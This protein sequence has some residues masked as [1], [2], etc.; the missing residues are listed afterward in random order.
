MKK[1]SMIVAGGM[2]AMGV[3][4]KVV[5]PKFMTDNMVVQRN[6]VLT[7]PGTA[8]PGATVTVRTD[9]GDGVNVAGKAGKD[10]K[11][12]IEVPTPEAGGP[13]TMI[14]SDGTDGGDVVLSNVLSGEVWLCSGQS[15]MEYPVRGWSEVMNG[16]VVSAESSQ[17]PD[18]RLLEI[19]HNIQYSPQEDAD[20][21]NG[22]WVEASP[23]T[24]EFS[25]VAYLFALE[26]QKEVG[27]PVG[28]IDASW[29]GTPAEAWVAYET[30]EGIDGF[31]GARKALAGSGF[32]GEKIAGSYEEQV[33]DWW[34]DVAAR[35][36][37]F[38]RGEMQA[39]WKKMNL[40]ELWD[41]KLMPGFDGV[42]WYQ[43]ELELPAVAAGKGMKLSVAQVD[44]ADDTYVNGVRVGGEVTAHGRRVYD[45]DGELVKGGKNVVSV[46]VTDF[47]GGGG[48]YGNAGDMWAEVDGVRY[49]LAGE[50]S[51][52]V[53]S[54]M[55]ELPRM[56]VDPRSPKYPTVLYN[57]MIKPISVMPVRGVL[58]YQGC[59]NVGR[60]KQYEPLFKGLINN[61]RSLYGQEDM[62]FYFVQLAG[63]LTQRNVQ[64]ESEWAALRDAQMKALELPNT[65]MA[66][67]ID[68]GH[69]GDIHP[70]NKQEVARR[71]SLIALNR[72]YGKKDVVYEAPKCVGVKSEGGKLS[73]KFDGPVRSASGV[74]T[75]FIVGDKDGKFAYAKSEW[76]GDDELVLSSPLISE[77]VEV[78]YNW[79]DYPGGNLRGGTGLP[80]AP[81]ARKQ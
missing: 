11:F 74:A 60:A 38:D 72:D 6:A 56:P 27:V 1:L 42:V 13:F 58:W 5:L 71:L 67:A 61:W 54:A 7:V 52:K 51:Y 63:W 28:V 19:R 47:G 44:D 40:P 12:R 53:G 64:P 76:R 32:S 3:E 68:L 79:A 57:G 62:P 77:P 29:G 66:V 65:G 9:W 2:I 8:A 37:K 35:D 4:A 45:V 17:H 55:S 75:G 59:D 23:A 14:V 43:R 78:R 69:P 46:R 20:V 16:D 41:E 31:E 25:A 81:F 39:G 15:N 50:W 49:D 34:D 80:V 18:I 73:V 22:G 70:V 26:I 48:I 36:L 21:D 10:G 24:M 33:K 30:L